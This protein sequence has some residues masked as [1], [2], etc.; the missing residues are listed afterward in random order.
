MAWELE[1]IRARHHLMIDLHLQGMSN[2]QIAEELDCTDV[3][4]GMV[5]RSPKVQEIIAQ[6]RNAIEKKIDDSYAEELKQAR[7]IL[8]KATPRAAQKLSD[9]IDHDDPRVAQSSATKVL[10]SVFGKDNTNAAKT[11]V[12]ISIKQAN[13][14]MAALNES[15]QLSSTAA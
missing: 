3:S 1:H 13:V 14:L 9:Q 6:R 8:A 7:A 11:V 5:L 12:Q 4:V 10:E 2:I 15:G